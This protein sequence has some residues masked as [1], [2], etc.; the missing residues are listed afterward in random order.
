MFTLHSHCRACGL[1]KPAI[2]TLKVVTAP[3][4]TYGSNDRLVE[5]MDL[6]LQP[7]ANAF[8]DATSDQ[9]GYAPLK[10]LVCPE[11]GLAQLSVV[12]DPRILYSNYA[13]VTSHSQTMMKHFEALRED[14]LKDATTADS[15]LEIGSN[16][17]TLLAFLKN[18]PFSTVLGCD[19]AEN[20]A[21]I[22]NKNGIPT[23]CG[24]FTYENCDCQMQKDVVIAR[25][26]MCHVDDWTDFVKGLERVTHKESLVAIEVPY[27]RDMVQSHSFDQVYHE[28]LSFMNVKAMK[29]LLSKSSLHIHNVKHYPI[30]GGTIVMFLRR[31]ESR[32]Q[33]DPSVSEWVSKESNIVEEWKSLAT[34]K[35]RMVKELKDL[36]ADLKSKGKTIAAYGASAKSTVWIN[37]CGFTRNE[38]GFL[39]DE[40]PTKQYKLS[41]GSNIP[42]VD[43]GAL[44]RELPQYCVCYAWNFFKEIYDKEE[45]FRKYGGQ[46][47]VPVP[48]PQIVT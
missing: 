20:L 35:D 23:F 12:V 34:N 40:T 2:P 42:V 48:T 31:N 46:W 39:C 30:H 33:P 15:V 32:V 6:G 27:Y 19:P 14:I 37:A 1:G 29:A 21:K 11:C 47:I 43:P 5:V 26:V 16:D 45:I 41:P 22:A 10:V 4:G 25:H 18:N 8:A 17:G 24:M 44:T 13:Y 36:V 7:L 28:H 38:I 3:A 9:S